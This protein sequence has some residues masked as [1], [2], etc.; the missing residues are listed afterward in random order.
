MGSAEELVIQET[1]GAGK[2]GAASF[3]GGQIDRILV[4]LLECAIGASE[5]PPEL[6]CD[7]QSRPVDPHVLEE[8]VLS[9]SREKVVVNTFVVIALFEE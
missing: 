2:D 6:P 1:P 7:G 9:V 5:I 4:V 8:D 3:F